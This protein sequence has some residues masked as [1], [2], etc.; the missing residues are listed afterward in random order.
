MKGGTKVAKI[1]TTT[2]TVCVDCEFC[3]E[4][5]RRV[6]GCGLVEKKRMTDEV[7]KNGFPEWCPLPETLTQTGGGE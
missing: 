6:Y 1:L 4:L 5:G 2:L 3:N 7:V